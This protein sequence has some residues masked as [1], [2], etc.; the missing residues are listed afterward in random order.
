MRPSQ[1]LGIALVVGVVSIAVYAVGMGRRFSEASRNAAVAVRTEVPEPGP[2]RP[3]RCGNY[4]CA[5]QVPEL[6]VHRSS[7]RGEWP[8]KA[9]TAVLRCHAGPRSTAIVEGVE[10][11]LN[12]TAMAHGFPE[13]PV[14]IRLP[15]PTSGDAHANVGDLIDAA[16]ALCENGT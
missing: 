7:F 2:D 1:R 6:T 12:G 10:Y 5:S 16:N 4:W 9:D 8:F 3:T 11:G 13:P 15:D 14:T